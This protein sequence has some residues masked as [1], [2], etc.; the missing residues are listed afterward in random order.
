MVILTMCFP[1]FN[2]DDALREKLSESV[3]MIDGT[4][5]V[6]DLVSSITDADE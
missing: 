3:A 1:Y 5:Y 6:P 2:P 4:V